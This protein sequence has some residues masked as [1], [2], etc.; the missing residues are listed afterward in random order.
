MQI[1]TL[2]TIMSESNQVY[3]LKGAERGSDLTKIAIVVHGHL[4]SFHRGFRFNN[5]GDSESESTGSG[6]FGIIG[7]SA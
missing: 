6:W 4:I 3:I 1:T 5:N 7:A 2:S